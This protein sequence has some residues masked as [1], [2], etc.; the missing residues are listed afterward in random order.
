[1]K[2]EVNKISAKNVEKD[3]DENK[4]DEQ[5]NFRLQQLP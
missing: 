4:K 1:M 2:A 3:K 5:R